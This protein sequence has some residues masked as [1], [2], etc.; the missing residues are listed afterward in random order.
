MSSAGTIVTELCT[1]EI[2]APGIADL[3]FKMVSPS[4]LVFQAG[5]FLSIAVDA[6]M[7]SASRRSYSIASQSDD[8]QHLRFIIRV[9]PTG[10]A[11]ELLMSTP[12]GSWSP[13]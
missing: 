9:I 3:C 6:E 11:S 13:K 7:G 5:Q 12:L 10:T 1:R 2:I 8:G 4:A